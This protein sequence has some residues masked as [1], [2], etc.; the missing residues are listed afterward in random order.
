M[1]VGLIFSVRLLSNSTRFKPF[2]FVSFTFCSRL[3]FVE[4]AGDFLT[5]SSFGEKVAG[6]LLSGEAL[7]EELVGVVVNVSLVLLELVIFVVEEVVQLD[8]PSGVLGLS[9]LS[10]NAN[11]Q[12]RK[13]NKRRK[14]REV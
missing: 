9:V 5:N 3:A 2:V 14:E 8:K 13:H 10:N 7:V 12:D 11:K 1:H 4:C 6:L